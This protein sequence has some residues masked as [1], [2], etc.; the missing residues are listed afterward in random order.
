MHPFSAPHSGLRP[1]EALIILNTFESFSAIIADL[2]YGSVLDFFYITGTPTLRVQ[3]M[4]INE[5]FVCLGAVP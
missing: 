2:L 3:Y 1:R 4:A 5:A